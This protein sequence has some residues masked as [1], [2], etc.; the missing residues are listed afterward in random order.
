MVNNGL[1]TLANG[2]NS[3]RGGARPGAGR[4]KGKKP[5]LVSAAFAL[6]TGV[7][8]EISR[9]AKRAGQSRSQVVRELLDE[10]LKN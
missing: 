2:K 3:L 7:V 6:T 8:N 4:P 9:R 5:P 1:Q 10:A